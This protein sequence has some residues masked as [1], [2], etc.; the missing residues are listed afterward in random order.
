[1]A[2]I[3]KRGEAWQVKWRGLDGRQHAQGCP[4]HATAKRVK[5]AVE[6]ARSE[7]RDWSPPR[8]GGVPNLEVMMA[9]VIRSRSLRAS[10]GYARLLTIA[11]GQLC[12][13]IETQHRRSAMASDLSRQALVD[14]HCWLTQPHATE[15][16]PRTRA[17]HSARC[18]PRTAS[19][20]VRL[21][22]TLWA[23]LYAHDVHGPYVPRPPAHLNELPHEES[24]ALPAPT[25]S[26]M[27]AAILCQVEQLPTWYQDQL[28]LIARFT[29]LRA[30]QIMSLRWEWVDLDR[31]QLWVHPSV[32]KT[33]QER[34][35]RRV[36]LS[37]HLVERMAGWG[38]RDGY[39]VD[40][41]TPQRTVTRRSVQRCW[42]A[43]GVRRE[44][45]SPT[46]DH[47]GQ[48][49]HAFRHGVATGLL[50]GGAPEYLV[51][52]FLGHQARTVTTS[53][54]ADMDS[55]M[56]PQLREVVAMIPPIIEQPNVVSLDSRRG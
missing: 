28:L 55:L 56:L 11:A 51:A 49:L 25:W 50:M 4:D 29:G 10:A 23:D 37:P 1:M 53:T 19:G 26:E 33:Q 21:V 18:S 54:Y 44:V 35:G 38:R 45:W 6:S 43:A 48:P 41:G 12:T 13:V 46:E 15:H 27:D 42:E 20:R 47:R 8:P 22:L 7:G 40:T 5:L 34:R 3:H 39:V 31:A 2:S 17:Q 52:R 30:S 32:G 16:N 36:P 24:P 14:L 9:D